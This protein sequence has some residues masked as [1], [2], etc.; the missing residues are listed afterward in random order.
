MQEQLSTPTALIEHETSW[1]MET[2]SLQNTSSL[3]R[4][5]LQTTPSLLRILVKRRAPTN[6]WR[7][8]KW[9][10]FHAHSRYLVKLSAFISWQS[11]TEWCASCWT[12]MVSAIT[13]RWPSQH[14]NHYYL[15]TEPCYSG[16]HTGPGGRAYFPHLWASYLERSWGYP[17]GEGASDCGSCLVHGLHYRTRTLPCLELVRKVMMQ[18]ASIWS[19]DIELFCRSNKTLRD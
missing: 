6:L 8:R 5:S 13:K 2:H 4:P 11:I 9:L 16:Y 14:G 7:K 1:R 19:R 18:G 12:P 10:V 17:D 3:M 15:F